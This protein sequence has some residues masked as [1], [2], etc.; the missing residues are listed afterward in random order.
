M[1]KAHVARQRLL[2]LGIFK[3]VE[4]LIDTSE[5]N[6][7]RAS[8]QKS[9]NKMDSLCILLKPKYQRTNISDSF[10]DYLP[11]PKVSNRNSEMCKILSVST[12]SDHCLHFCFWLSLF[13]QRRFAQRSGCNLWGDR[14]KEA[15]RKLQHHGWQQWRKHGE[16]NDTHVCH[17]FLFMMECTR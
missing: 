6:S 15:D 13:R 12:A 10:V 11:S 17:I 5:G 2:R 9:C 7:F 3:E 8:F 16:R 4:V 14:D 1:K